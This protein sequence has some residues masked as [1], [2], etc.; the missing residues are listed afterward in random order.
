MAMCLV[1]G[2]IVSGVV[3]DLGDEGLLL[4]LENIFKKFVLLRLILRSPREAGKDMMDV[5]EAVL[6]GG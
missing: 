1:W 2:G 4:L 6:F 3:S 5:F